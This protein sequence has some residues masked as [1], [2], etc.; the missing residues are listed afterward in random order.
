ME[1][2]RW[3]QLGLLFLQLLLISSLPR[4]TVSSVQDAP[5]RP[6]GEGALRV[7]RQTGAFV[8]GAWLVALENGTR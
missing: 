5:G 4:G 2:G 8:L 7:S 3:T 6:D 1:L